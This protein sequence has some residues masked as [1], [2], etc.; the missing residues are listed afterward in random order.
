MK[1]GLVDPSSVDAGSDDP[2][3]P[4]LDAY[5]NFEIPQT[6]DLAFRPDPHCP[7]TVISCC[8]GDRCVSYNVDPNHRFCK[9]IVCCDSIDWTVVLDDHDHLI[10]KGK[11][12]KQ[13]PATGTSKNGVQ[14]FI[15]N[16]IFDNGVHGGGGGG[17]LAP[18]AAAEGGG[19]F[20]W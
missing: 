13:Q 8:L 5:Q 11:S 15:N 14:N 6:Y 18:P 7:G 12:C 10:G 9:N 2:A 16:L 17:G 1:K 20:G 19:I 4:D 3:Q